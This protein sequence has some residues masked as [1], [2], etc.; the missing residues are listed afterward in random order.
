[1]STNTRHSTLPSIYY[2]TFTC[3]HWLA[4]FEIVDG[5]SLVYDWFCILKDKLDV[6]TTG[7]VIMPNH[8]HCLLFFPT[9]QFDLSKIIANGKRFMAYEIISR[10]ETISAGI[11]LLQLQEGLTAKQIEKGQK[12]KVF[13]ESFDAKPV[14]HRDFLLQKLQYIHLNPVRGKWKLVEHWEEYEHS[15]AR[16]YVR[17]KIDGFVP[18][19]YEELS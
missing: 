3:R 10:L 14:Y 17:N 19:H 13:E 8:V 5:Y 1:M 18:V 16:F 7:Y 2:V 9:D 11:I 15:S 4:L 12:H 6:K